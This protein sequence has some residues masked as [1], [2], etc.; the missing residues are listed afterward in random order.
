MR[1]GFSASGADISGTCVIE[2]HGHADVSSQLL[3][4]GAV[5]CNLSG[6]GAIA[7]WFADVRPSCSLAPLVFTMSLPQSKV[8]PCVFISSS[9]MGRFS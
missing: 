3:G 8:A 7:Q 2:L 1:D 5:E 6:D 4:Q 9:P